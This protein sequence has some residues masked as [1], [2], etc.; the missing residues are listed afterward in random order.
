MQATKQTK[1]GTAKTQAVEFKCHAPD[2]QLVFVAGTFNEWK[3]DASPLVRDKA[4]NWRASLKLP[5]GRHEFKFV[6]DGRWCCDP[7]CVDEQHGCPNCCANP[8]GTMNRILEV[9]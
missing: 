8:F 6:V 3:P 2:A 4:G 5:A 9:S 1:A 7:A